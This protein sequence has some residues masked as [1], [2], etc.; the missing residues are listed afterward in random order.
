MLYQYKFTLFLLLFQYF[1]KF[2][3]NDIMKIYF[4]NTDIYFKE[5]IINEKEIIISTKLFI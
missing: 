1:T 3:F 4:L 2:F 5:A